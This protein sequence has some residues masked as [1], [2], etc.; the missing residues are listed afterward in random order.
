MY[1]HHKS[2]R[3]KAEVAQ[4]DCLQQSDHVFGPKPAVHMGL[5]GFE[6]P[7]VGGGG[8]GGHREVKGCVCGVWGGGG[9]GGSGRG[10]EA[11]TLSP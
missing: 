6:T 3:S 11:L 4:K 5:A 10:S 2:Y 1:S 8:E 7:V 9:G